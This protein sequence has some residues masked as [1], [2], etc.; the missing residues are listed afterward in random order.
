MIQRAIDKLRDQRDGLADRV[1]ELEEELQ[2]AKSYCK[3]W[4]DI[5]KQQRYKLI[6]KLEAQL[7]AARARIQ[8]LIDECDEIAFER[9]QYVVKAGS[10]E[11]GDPMCVDKTTPWWKT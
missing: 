4:E 11:K 5:A 7:T 10:V 2:D 8:E 6:T 9:V 1:E 3:A